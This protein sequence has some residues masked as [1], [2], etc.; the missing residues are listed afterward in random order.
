MYGLSRFLHKPVGDVSGSISAADIR[1]SATILIRL[2]QREV[3]SEE[4]SILESEDTTKARRRMKLQS[5]RLRKLAPFLNDGIIRVG[6]RLTYLPIP[7]SVKHPILMPSNHNVTRLL[8]FHYHIANDHVGVQHTLAEIQRRYW[9]IGGIGAV[10]RVL[11][12]CMS[13]RIRN[14]RPMQQLMAPVIP[15]QYAVYQQAFSTVGVD[16]FGP[17][18]VA[19]GRVR[20]RRYGCLFTCLTTRAIQIEVSP[21]LDTDSFLCAFTRFAARRGWPSRV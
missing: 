19:R 15:D 18:I 4:I 10:K 12:R 11:N 9:I 20:E 21:L 2:L 14:A 7:F 16:Y 8:I 17:I 3:F 1:N 6:G 5:S 13:C